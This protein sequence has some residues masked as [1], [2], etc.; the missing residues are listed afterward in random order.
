MLEW[1]AAALAGA[2]I[3]NARGEAGWIVAHVLGL[4]SGLD[5]QLYSDRPFEA[6]AWRKVCG[7][8]ERRVGGEPLQYVLGTAGFYGM[9]LA[10]GPG[11]LIPRPETERLVDVA[12]ELYPG[13]GSVCDLCT[14]SGAVALALARELPGPPLVV[15]IDISRDA[16]RY[17]DTNRRHFTVSNLRLVAGD[18]LTGLKASARF[19]LITVNPPYVDPALFGKLPPEIVDHEPDLALVAAERGLAVIRGIAESAPAHLEAGGWLLCEISSEQ[20]KAARVLFEEAGLRETSVVL[21][22]TG[23]DRIV[24]GRAPDSP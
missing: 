1:V 7:M 11:V 2:G 12:I 17:A 16:L 4:R 3:G 23:R 5:A 18:L 19:T 22:Y 8:T 13:A 20:G 24:V 14:G 9:N 10:V 15:G 6:E 21:D